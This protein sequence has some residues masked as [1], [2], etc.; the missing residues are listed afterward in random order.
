[1]KKFLLIALA[2]AFFMTGTLSA[3]AADFDMAK[4]SC[5]DFTANPNDMQYTMFWLD[6][7]ASA[8][9]EDTV[10]SQEWMEE[11]T[12]YMVEFCQGNPD[13]TIMNALEA[14]GEE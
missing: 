2:S 1:M 5:K 6:G 3:Q 9:S 11:F 12:K 4:M 13:K 10:T 7:Y 8:C 14:L